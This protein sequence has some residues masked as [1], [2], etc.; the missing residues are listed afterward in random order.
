MAY[1]LQQA[2]NGLHAGMLYAALAFGYALINGVLHRTNLAHGAIFALCGQIAIMAGILGYDR[3]WLTWPAAIGLAAVVSLAYGL[4]VGA[5]LARWVLG[6]LVGAAPNAVTA[7]TL[8]ALIVLAE[9]GRIAADTRDVWLPPLWSTPVIFATISGF[10][11]SLTVNQLAGIATLA[12]AIAVAAFILARTAL[13]RSWRAVSDDPFAA[14]LCGV[15]PGR[16]FNRAVLAGSF[17]A[18]LAGIAAALHYGNIGFGAGLIY[19]LKILFVTA[20]GSYA[21]PLLAAGGALAYGVG[22]ALWTGYFPAEWR[23]GWMLAFLV[24]LLVLRAEGRD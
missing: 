16:T 2:L 18:A 22:E 1:F 21:S 24:V 4:L 5:T 14:A 19:G 20:A 6:P 12:A 8:G 13:G 17:L 9:I 11:V 10:S 7:A 23:D 3:L 15:D